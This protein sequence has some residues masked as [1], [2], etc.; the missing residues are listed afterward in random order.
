MVHEGFTAS[1]GRTVLVRTDDL[2]PAERAEVSEFFWLVQ[3]IRK[4]DDRP[5]DGMVGAVA[6]GLLAV[7]ISTG[8]GSTARIVVGFLAILGTVVTY[9]VANGY[10][11]K[12]APAVFEE[13]LAIARRNER[14]RIA[15]SQLRQASEVYAKLLPQLDEPA[16]ART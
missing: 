1:I 14:C 13:L 4:L 8:L 3:R 2:T 15:A 10:A 6:V 16:T 5:F 7:L 9:G 12:H 11:R